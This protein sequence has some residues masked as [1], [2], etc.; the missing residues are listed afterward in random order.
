MT[1]LVILAMFFVGSFF[2]VKGMY[3]KDPLSTT[4]GFT[5]ALWLMAIGVLFLICGYFAIPIH[6]IFYLV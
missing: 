4:I 1:G 2:W 5:F 3:P 6:K